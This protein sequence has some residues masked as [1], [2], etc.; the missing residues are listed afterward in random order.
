MKRLRPLAVLPCRMTRRPCT[1]WSSHTGT[2]VGSSKIA[3]S[4]SHCS[5]SCLSQSLSSTSCGNHTHVILTTLQFVVHEVKGCPIQG[6]RLNTCQFIGGARGL[7]KRST[8]QRYRQLVPEASRVRARS[9]S[10]ATSDGQARSLK[11]NHGHL[12]WPDEL[13]VIAGP[14]RTHPAD[15]PDKDEAAG[16]SPARPTILVLTCG[17][18]RRLSPSIAA[19]AVRRLRTPVSERIPALL[20]L[21][22]SGRA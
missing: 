17:N 9:S 10:R 8:W 7:V 22:D 11:D 19:G 6:R 15:M 18:S 16:S 12:R 4:T 21:D 1:G 14:A 20:S 2:A 13:V 3:S 5:S